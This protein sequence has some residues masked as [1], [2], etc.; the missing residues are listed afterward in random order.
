MEEGASIECI[1]VA[2]GAFVD[3]T[4]N[5]IFL[6]KKGVYT[7]IYVATSNLGYRTIKEYSLNAIE[8]VEGPTISVDFENKKVLKD[9]V[10]TVPVATATDAVD[11]ETEVKVSVMFGLTS[12]ELTND[13]FSANEYGTYIITY[14]ATD[15]YGNTTSQSFYVEVQEEIQTET[16][17]SS[18]ENDNNDSNSSNQEP[19]S[20]SSCS[21]CNG[22]GSSMGIGFSGV[23]FVLTGV[24]LLL[25]KR[26]DDN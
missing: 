26:K 23:A 18:T 17:D 19:N 22:C 1:V 24:Y 21:N 2:D 6:E 16:N 15:E 11:G 7:I 10:I 3:V 5:A 20:S 4:N 9:T 13:E 25:K 12:V 8:D 14:T